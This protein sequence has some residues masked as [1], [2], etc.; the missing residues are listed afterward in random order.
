M[1]TRVTA[2]LACAV[3]LSGC[4][5]SG[6]IEPFARISGRL[7]PVAGQTLSGATFGPADYAGRILIV[8]FWN[9]DCPPCREESPVLEQASRDLRSHGAVVVGIVFTGHGWPDDPAAA[10]A[11]LE[12]EGVGYASLV[13]PTLALARALDVV[14]IPTT[15]VADRTGMLR[16]RLLGKVRPGQ[17]E[18]IV[19]QIG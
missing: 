5:S 10:R 4:P 14:G 3:L 7:P 19:D 1:F 11:F 15:I 18:R 17:L 2:T 13:D 6:S 8:N 12:E 16:F 9:Q